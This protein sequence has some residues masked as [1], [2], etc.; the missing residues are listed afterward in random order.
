LV[1]NLEL[2]IATGFVGIL[3]LVGFGKDQGI[4]GNFGGIRD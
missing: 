2:D 4:M 1:T 3:L